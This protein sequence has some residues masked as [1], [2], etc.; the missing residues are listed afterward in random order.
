MD[1]IGEALQEVA[2]AYPRMLEDLRK[3]MFSALGQTEGEFEDLWRRVTI[4]AGLSGDLRL[5]ALAVRMSEMADAQAD[6]ETVASLVI[7]RGARSRVG[8]DRSV[9]PGVGHRRGL[10]PVH[11]TRY[12][13][14]G[15]YCVPSEAIADRHRNSFGPQSACQA[16]LLARNREVRKASVGRHT[17]HDL[18]AW[19]NDCWPPN[20]LH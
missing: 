13:L 19:C 1:Q 12:R 14:H 17:F 4:V 6:M 3:R 2:Q 11:R 16:W 20:R 18:L 9:R 7:A 5:D 15:A 10:A 8:A